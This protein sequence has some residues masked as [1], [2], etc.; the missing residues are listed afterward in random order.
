MR[1]SRWSIICIFLLSTLAAVAG[2]ISEDGA[3]F[4]V[5][6]INAA[7]LRSW[8]VVEQT[9]NVLPEG[10]YWG[11]EYAGVRGEE[12]VLQGSTDV[13]VS[14][15]DREGTWHTEAIG[16]EA[17]KLYIMPST[18]KERCWRIFIPKRTIS[19]DLLFENRT[20]KIYA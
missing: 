9:P 13:H 10:H 19:A 6:K 5:A 7:V 12:I 16:K 1:Q 20:V 17:L 11:Q 3:A 4:V 8:T 2:D 18:Y 15:Q 14:W